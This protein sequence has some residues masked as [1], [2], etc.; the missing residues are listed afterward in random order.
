MRAI[1]HLPGRNDGVQ[2]LL[3]LA[4]AF[5]PEQVYDLILLCRTARSRDD[6]AGGA[7]LVEL[8]RRM[9]AEEMKRSNVDYRRARLTVAARLG[10]RDGGARSNFYKVLAGGKPP[11]TRENSRR[12]GGQHGGAHDQPERN[13][14]SQP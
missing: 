9:I 13:T 8:G 7:A 3:S 14:E 1:S 2:G 12:R 11:E 4:D 6:D 5:G 10:Y